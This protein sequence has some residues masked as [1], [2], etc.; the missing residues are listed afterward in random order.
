MTFSDEFKRELLRASL[1]PLALAVQS[2]LVPTF[3]VFGVQPSLFLVVFVFYVLRSGALAGV[4][5]GFFCGLLL[6]TYASQVMGA[7]SVALSIV[8]FLVGQLD[9]RRVHLGYPMRVMV[10]GLGALLNDTIWH[11]VS[12][13]GLEHLAGFLFRVALPSSCYTMLVGAIVFALRPP[14]KPLRNW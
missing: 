8:G 12:R 14:R 5:M 6:D 2:I 9:E 4:W 11:L 7:N 10:L 13:H 3:S 1:V